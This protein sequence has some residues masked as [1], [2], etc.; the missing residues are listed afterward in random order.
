MATVRILRSTTPGAVPASLV[1]GQLAINE[2]DAKLFYRNGSG[3]VTEFTGGGGSAAAI[4]EYATPASFPA[5]GATGKLYLSTDDSRAYRWDSTNS[6]YVEVA[7]IG[8]VPDTLDG[9]TYA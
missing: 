1:S 5:T 6:V 8:G 3:V 4:V 2:A 9:G 7:A